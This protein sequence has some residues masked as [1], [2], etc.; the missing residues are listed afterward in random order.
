MKNTVQEGKLGKG[1][2]LY[3]ICF[4]F[5]FFAL[6]CST[7]MAVEDLSKGRGDYIS[8]SFAVFVFLCFSYTTGHML[9]KLIKAKIDS[10][11][12]SIGATQ[13]HR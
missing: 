6:I 1:I 11:N 4:V 5:F 3:G 8:Y 13:R 12:H 2:F 7:A 10:K 9:I